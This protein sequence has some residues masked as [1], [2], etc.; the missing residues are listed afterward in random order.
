MATRAKQ[1]NPDTVE[2]R[3]GRWKVTVSLG[4]KPNGSRRC[5]VVYGDTKKAAEQRA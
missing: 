2:I 3:P 1:G 4:T 5:E